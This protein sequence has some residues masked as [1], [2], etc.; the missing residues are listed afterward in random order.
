M[1]VLF[2]TWAWPSHLYAL[3]PL[4]WACRA[5]G[6]EVLIAGQPELHDD[7]VRTGLPAARVGHDVDAAGL[8][9]G[10]LLPS[11]AVPAPVAPAGPEGRGPRA[12]RMFHA[13][14]DS[15]VDDLTAL[16]RDWR[17]DL[18][19][20]EPTALAGPIAAAAAGVPAARLLYGTDLLLRAR[21]LL[22]EVL[23]PLAERNGVGAFDPFGAVTVDPC[24][25][26]FQVPVDYR[27]LP[28]RYVPFN[29]SGA[30]P[31][32]PAPAPGRRRVVVTWGHT[33]AKL[34]PAHFLAPQ[35]ALAAHGADTDVVLAVSSEQLPLLGDLPEDITVTVDAPL[36]LLLTDADLV[37]SHG[38][39]GTV[40]T[41]LQ[42]G[43]PLLLVP[44]LPDH[45]GHSARVLAVGAG[46]VLSR[47]EAEPE[48]MRAEV[49]RLLD[50]EHERKAA[51][52]LRERNLQ[53][54]APADLVADLEELA[55]H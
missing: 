6:H 1:R 15:M 41:T 34:S 25:D 22:P 2:T 36:H 29:G 21:G 40:L 47:D 8:V 51:R 38:G 48:R 33:M 39:A 50:S 12:M 9:R 27:R 4:A 43:L 37:V 52:R 23:A 42:A 16:A 30:G 13:H 14:A 5:A 3:V 54:P 28:M 20:Y 10:Y 55:D 26:E 7:I 11:A 53:R 24:P 35:A 32:L 44:Q 17:A 49:R 18:V 46:E 45:A 31:S 19:V